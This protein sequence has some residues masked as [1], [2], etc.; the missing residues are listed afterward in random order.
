MALKNALAIKTLVGNTDL[1]LKADVGESFLV[2]DIFIF[3]PAT[4][5]VTI[6]TE[7][8]T[9]GY[10]RVSGDLGSHLP[11]PLSPTNHSL[12]FSLDAGAM[13]SVE[14]NAIKNAAGTAL[15]QMF[16]AEVDLA[17]PAVVPRMTYP[18]QIL[19][20]P[21]TIL[22]YMKDLGLFN[23]YPVATGETLK[24]TGAAQASS[25][26][27]V[28]YEIYDGEDIKNT[29]PNGSKAREYFFLNYGRPSTG[30]SGSEDS[31]YSVIQ[32]PAEFP[33]F[34]YGKTVPAKTEIDLIGILSSDICRADSDVDDY[35]YSTYLKL[36]FERETLFDEDRNGIL[37]RGINPPDTYDLYLIAEG[38]SFFGN[39][40]SVDSKP[41]FIFPSPMTFKEGD[42]LNIYLSTV[43]VGAGASLGAAWLETALILGVRRAE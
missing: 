10:F 27:C 24:I 1:E 22:S 41:P 36:V 35:T 13:A 12:G 29:D 40:S 28:L 8:T 21:K 19:S 42:E 2:K 6:K 30:P 17:A 18:K 32:S 37:H 15:D 33:D 16:A 38:Q 14:Y 39:Y 4:S 20:S 23:G 25:I 11:F 26:Q 34:P 5:Y 3:S 31:L 9:T 7:K 43:A